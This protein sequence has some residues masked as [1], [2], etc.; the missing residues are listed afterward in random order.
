MNK[1]AKKQ[2]Y[3]IIDAIAVGLVFV[4]SYMLLT[5]I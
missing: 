4:F 1:E 2:K 3:I 5:L